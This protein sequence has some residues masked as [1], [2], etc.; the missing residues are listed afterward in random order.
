MSRVSD[1][2]SDPA[3]PREPKRPAPRSRVVTRRVEGVEREQ[4]RPAKAVQG[5]GEEKFQEEKKVEP[6]RS[7][8]EFLILRRIVRSMVLSFGGVCSNEC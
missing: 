4:V 7:V 5:S 8:R 2:G 3:S 6:G 1:S